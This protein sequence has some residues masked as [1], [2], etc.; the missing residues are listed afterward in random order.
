ME[1][2]LPPRPGFTPATGRRGSGPCLWLHVVPTCVANPS[3]LPP[4]DTSPAL[5]ADQLIRDNLLIQ[6]LYL[7]RIC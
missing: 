1:A 3:C 7:G 5:R 6:G 4:E 2:P